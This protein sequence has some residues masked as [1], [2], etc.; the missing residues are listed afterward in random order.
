MDKPRITAELGA[1]IAKCDSARIPA[2]A[3]ALALT[4]LVDCCGVLV[5][6]STEEAPR[7][8]E[9][10][11]A[12][13]RRDARLYF[14]ERRTGVAAAAWINATA[15]HALDFDDMAIQGHPSAVLA[16]SLLAEAAMRD[17][18]GAQI[19]DAYLIGYEVWAELV[20][21]E[22]SQHHMRGWHPTGLF[23]G[24]G[25][26]A[27][28]ARLTG[29]DAHQAT[30]ALALAASQSSG[31]VANFGTMA[32]PL[33][34]GRAAH[35]GVISARMAA[36]GMSAAEDAIEHP[37]GL[38]MATSP[39]GKADLARPVEAG[40]TWRILSHGLNIKRYPTCYSITR[41]ADGVRALMQ[42]HGF[43]AA[44]V[45]AVIVSMSRRN[46]TILLHHKPTTA[47]E[48]KFSMEF[49]TA[50]VLATGSLTL[51]ELRDDFVRRPDI[52]ALMERVTVAPLDQEDAATGYAPADTVVI[53]LQSGAVFEIKVSKSPHPTPQALF[54]KF[55]SCLKLGNFASPAREF[56]DALMALDQ[57]VPARELIGR[58]L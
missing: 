44:D 21:R 57:P 5:A 29:L 22:P 46:A 55:E 28:C 45:A 35:A 11:L 31:L 43:Q 27:A 54:D 17:V 53:R 36:Q 19:I 56:H 1:F 25:A 12:P 47:L 8:L 58:W 34:V 42:E 30:M 2:P 7:I 39:S 51:S 16:P 3:R 48:A 18:T 23:G 32:K 40:K 41:G 9:K 38:M 49:A 33:H 10:T 24:I 26:A 4:G 50:A 14:G 37:Q 15:A 20:L 6:G 13:A 52:Q